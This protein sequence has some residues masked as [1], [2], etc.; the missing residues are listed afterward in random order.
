MSAWE[1]IVAIILFIVALTLIITIH[2]LGHFSMAKLFNVYCH[3][4]SIG[5][6]PA[7]FKKKRKNGETTFVFRAIPFGG[8]VAMYGED[9]QFDEAELVLTEDRSIEGIKKWKKIIIVTAGVFLNAVTALVLMFISNVAFPVMHTSSYADVTPNSISYNLG[10]REDNRITIFHGSDREIT[11]EDGS[12][13]IM[14]YSATFT[15]DKGSLEAAAFFILDPNVVLNDTHYV[16]TYYPVTNKTNN[17]LSECL[18]LY[19][20]VTKDELST[21]EDLMTMFKP[22]SI[23][24]KAPDYYPNY[25]KKFEYKNE[26]ISAVLTFNVAAEG[27]KAEYKSFN[28][29]FKTIDG[30]MEDFGLS[31]KIVKEWLPFKERLRNTFIDFGDASVAVFR[32]IGSLFTGGIRNMSG[33]VGIFN[34]SAEL[35]SSYTFARYL[36]FWGLISVNLAIFNLLPFPGLDG[37]QIVVTTIEGISKKKIPNKVKTI[38]SYIG[39]GLVFALMIAI[40]AIDI[41]RIAGVI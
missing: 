3:E 25:K 9:T 34:I 31:L 19:V 24:E 14:P 28:F 5:F 21:D 33:F 8:Y 20:G 11:N 36:Y 32:G 29:T 22:W 38:V 37:W 30:K 41:M 1:W 12:T 40:L 16:L 27:Q 7:L 2:E 35:Y 13:S 4:F 17:N 18:K 39:L 10:I 6:G 23:E 26:E 15:N